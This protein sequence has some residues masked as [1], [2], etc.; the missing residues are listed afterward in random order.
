VTAP[1]TA[2]A[3]QLLER[4]K[5]SVLAEGMRVSPEALEHLTKGGTQAL[6]IH[7]YPTTGGITMVL[8]H[9]VYLNAPFDEWYCEGAQTVLDL[10]NGPMGLTLRHPDGLLEVQSVLPLPGYLD[11]RDAAGR[12]VTEVAMS[13]ADRVRLSPIVGC[14]YD[15]G[16]CDLPAEQYTIRDADQLLV[17]LAV[18]ARDRAL[19]ARHVLISGGS[20]RRTHYDRFIEI[21]ERV[22]TA[23]PLPVDV[24]FSPMIDRPDLVPRLVD[25]GAAGFA[26]NIEV[27]ATEPAQRALR[28][29]YRTVRDH[30]ERTI[31]DA[32]DALGREG[33]VRSLIIVGLEPPEDTLAGVEYLASLGCAPTLSP[34]RPAE[35]T[36]LRILP[37]PS[38]AHLAAVLEESRAIV[39]RHGVPLGPDC[40]PCQHNTLTF[41]WDVA[42][43]APSAPEPAR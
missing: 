43:A 31:V 17:A 2:S 33:Q 37:P 22:I 32:V 39:A 40:V 16:F 41:P 10:G 4:V 21:C 42:P 28:S 19:P 8:D 30:L 9:D 25:A 6:T 15:C 24:M 26:I 29:K 36:R 12:P 20:P 7:E 1:A 18:A 23:S 11:E 27:F 3:R 13:H 14:A 34:F 38:A 5:T 35:G